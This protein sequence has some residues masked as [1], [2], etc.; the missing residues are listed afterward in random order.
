MAVRFVKPEHVDILREYLDDN[1]VVL[2]YPDQQEKAISLG[3]E[4]EEH[5]DGYD[6]GGDSDIIVDR[7]ADDN[8]HFFLAKQ[9]ENS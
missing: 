6:F 1:C 8:H 2:I 5:L 4:D 7:V 9:E 3:I